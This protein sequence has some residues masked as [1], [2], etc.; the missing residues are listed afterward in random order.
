MKNKADDKGK[1]KTGE[2]RRAFLKKAAAGAVF[3]APVMETF[4]K[5]D[6]LLKSALAQTGPLSFVITSSVSSPNS[7]L[8]DFITPLGTVS[9]IRGGS[10][11][12]T[13]NAGL[14][15]NSSVSID[16]DGNPIP[17]YPLI[18]PPGIPP[19]GTTYTFTNVQANHTIQ[20]TVT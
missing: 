12:F 6:I 3:A 18:A 11:T 15:S 4:T 2:T 16:V 9:V 13:I 10:Q 8:V 20:L 17:G 7:P 1:S 5:S 14:T 19:V